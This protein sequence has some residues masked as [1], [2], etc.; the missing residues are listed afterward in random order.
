VAFANLD[1]S[2]SFPFITM[3]LFETNAGHLREEENV[4]VIAFHP[5]VRHIER[6]DWEAYSV[7]EQG[8]IGQAR[9]INTSPHINDNGIQNDVYYDEGFTPFIQE[10]NEWGFKIH[11]KERNVS[12]H[13]DCLGECSCRPVDFLTNFVLSYSI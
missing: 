9:A 4:E 11:A 3:P 8:W 12:I 6:A 1:D 10:T 5:L 2:A 13:A 7:Q